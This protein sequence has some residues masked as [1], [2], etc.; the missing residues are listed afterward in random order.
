MIGVSKSW[1]IDAVFLAASDGVRIHGWYVTHPDARV[2]FAW[3]DG[4]AG[5]LEDCQTQ[6]SDLRSFRQC[7]S[8]INYCG[9]GVEHGHQRAGVNRRRARCLR[10]AGVCGSTRAQPCWGILCESLGGGVAA[11]AMTQALCA[12]LI[13]NHIRQC[14]R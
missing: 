14:E 11:G 8:N 7:V 2:N 6:F 4:N 9:Y 12:G 5:N 13:R 10:L 1:A 3:S